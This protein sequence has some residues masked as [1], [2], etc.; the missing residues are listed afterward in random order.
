[1]YAIR[2]YYASIAPVTEVPVG[3]VGHVPGCVRLEGDKGIGR[4][5]LL[6]DR[7][8]TPLG[9]LARRTRTG[10]ERDGRP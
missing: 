1:M 2:S 7:L 6:V 9:Q 5:R 8:E 10:P 3:L 4:R